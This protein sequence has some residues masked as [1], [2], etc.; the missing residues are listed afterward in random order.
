M[1]HFQVQLAGKWEDYQGQEDKMLKRAFLSGFPKSKYQFR[2]QTYTYDFVENTQTNAT[3]GKERPIRPPHKFK[4][5]AAPISAG[6]KS[7]FVKVPP[8]KAGQVIYVK[9]PGHKGK[10]FPVAVPATG[11]AGGPMLVTVP[12]KETA[13]GWSTGAKVAAGGAAAVGVAGAAVG[14]VMLADHLAGGD[15]GMIGDLADGIEEVAGDVA[16]GAEDVAGDVA[17][18]AEEAADWVGEAGGDVGDFF[19]DLF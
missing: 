10:K 2:G 6:G 13:G 12:E 5:P 3:T 15:E 19:M 7:K 4:R 8:G 1:S 11:G 18:F 17:D 16:D 14:G 9:H